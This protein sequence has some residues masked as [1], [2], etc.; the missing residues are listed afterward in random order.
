MK[1]LLF[2]EQP[3]VL[4][5]SCVMLRLSPAEALCAATL[6]AAHSV[7]RSDRQGALQP[8]MRADMLVI[9]APRL[10][11]S[12]G[13]LGGSYCSKFN[14][15]FSVILHECDDFQILY[16]AAFNYVIILK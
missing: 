6:N 12:R 4:H 1:L 13:N 10:V 16:A 5:L 9:D 3:T 7:R 14:I 8:G 11:Q 2:H 15:Y